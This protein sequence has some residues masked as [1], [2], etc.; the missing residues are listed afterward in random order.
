MS[1]KLLRVS[2]SKSNKKSTGLLAG[3]AIC[4]EDI[5]DIVGTEKMGGGGLGEQS[6]QWICGRVYQPKCIKCWNCRCG[7][8]WCCNLQSVATCRLL[9]ALHCVALVHLLAAA[10]WLFD[11]IMEPVGMQLI[12]I[13]KYACALMCMERC[14]NIHTYVCLSVCL[15][16][17]LYVFMRAPDCLAAM[18]VRFGISF[19]VLFIVSNCCCCLFIHFFFACIGYCKNMN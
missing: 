5:V 14:T 1:Q 18:F 12:Q 4:I 15:S 9:R 3:L 6:K 2:T 11:A 16:L 19:L 8:R 17:C 10:A 13:Y 7:Q